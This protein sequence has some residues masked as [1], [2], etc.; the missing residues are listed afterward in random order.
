[1][2]LVGILLDLLQ[3]PDRHREYQAHHHFHMDLVDIALIRGRVCLLVPHMTGDLK[4]EYMYHQHSNV[5]IFRHPHMGFR[6]EYHHHL[7]DMLNQQQHPQDP[8]IALL[9]LHFDMFC[10]VSNIPFL[11]EDISYKF[12]PDAKFP[13]RLCIRLMLHFLDMVMY[14][15]IG[16][17]KHL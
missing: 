7:L 10:L 2:V 14:R 1:M 4:T 16:H 5:D 12:H 8:N 9:K 17:N 15:Q 11:L 6:R 3:F 13:H